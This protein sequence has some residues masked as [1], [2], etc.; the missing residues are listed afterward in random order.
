MVTNVAVNNVKSPSRICSRRRDSSGRSAVSNG[1]LLCCLSDAQ[2]PKTDV[3]SGRRGCEDLCLTYRD[4]RR[5]LLADRK[6]LRQLSYCVVGWLAPLATWMS[7]A[8]GALA[9]GEIE[10]HVV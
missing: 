7:E 4:T 3:S 10:D 8:T 9:I 5:L 1:I 2:I 6:I